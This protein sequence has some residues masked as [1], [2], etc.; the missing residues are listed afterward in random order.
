VTSLSDDIRSQLGKVS[1]VFDEVKS[2]IEAVVHF[3]DRIRDKFD[4]PAQNLVGN[5]EAIKNGVSAFWHSFR[6][7]N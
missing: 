5:L 7:K 1:W 6:R 2:K 3:Q 4:Y